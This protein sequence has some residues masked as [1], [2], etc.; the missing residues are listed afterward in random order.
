MAHVHVT[1][2]A[3]LGAGLVGLAC[4]HHLR[5]RGHAVLLIDPRGAGGETSFGNA[6][7]I[8]VGN[9]MPQSTPGI[10]LKGLRMLAD[11]L[12]PL[13][14]DQP[15]RPGYWRW[16]WEFVRHGQAERVMPIIDA[17]HA[18]NHASRQAWLDWAAAVDAD[19]LCGC[20]VV[21]VKK[22]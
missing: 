15:Q 13:K 14:L 18:I 19:D 10:V 2:V 1:E 7:S 4:A 21:C 9:V 16:L 8:S 11:P 12:A 20:A 6:G 17:L 22:A 5:Q 3:V